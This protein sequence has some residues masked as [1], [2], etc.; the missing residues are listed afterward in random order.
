MGHDIQTI[1]DTFSVLWRYV[2]D[3][4]GT[5]RNLLYKLSSRGHPTS[6]QK[7]LGPASSFFLLWLGII[8]WENL[9]I[10]Y[11]TNFQNRISSIKDYALPSNLQIYIQVKTCQCF[12]LQISVSQAQQC[13]LVLEHRSFGYNWL[14][15]TRAQNDKDKRDSFMS[16]IKQLSKD[17]ITFFI[18]GGSKGKGYNIVSGIN[19]LIIM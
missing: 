1:Q 7:I 3:F 14:Q 17:K 4:Y 6:Q 15:Q 9:I 5:W 12:G 10:A 16:Y 13:K 11:D 19:K 8:P 18:Q 2:I